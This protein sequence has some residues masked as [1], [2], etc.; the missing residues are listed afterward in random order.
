MLEIQSS[1]YLFLLWLPTQ[2]PMHLTHAPFLPFPGPT[3]QPTQTLRKPQTR[4][5][6]L[7]LSGLPSPNSRS[8]LQQ[9]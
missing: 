6:Q 2:R 1:P 5:V 3:G 7:C 4:P 9:L 8:Q